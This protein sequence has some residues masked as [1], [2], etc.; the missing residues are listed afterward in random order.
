MVVAS[1]AMPNAALAR[2]DKEEL[3]AMI[4]GYQ[5]IDLNFLNYDNDNGTTSTF[6]HTRGVT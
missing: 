3:E 5:M 1:G 4:P 2:Y 6:M